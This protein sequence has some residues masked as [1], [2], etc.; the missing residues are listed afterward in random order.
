MADFQAKAKFCQN[1]IVQLVFQTF[2][3]YICIDKIY[4]FIIISF[5]FR[6]IIAL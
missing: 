2:V 6:Q 1:L 4:K 5:F 3:L